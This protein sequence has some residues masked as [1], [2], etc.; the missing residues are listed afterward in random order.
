MAA[1]FKVEVFSAGVGRVARLSPRN[2]CRIVFSSWSRACQW[3]IAHNVLDGDFTTAGAPAFTYVWTTQMRLKSKIQEK[4]LLRGDYNPASHI[5]T[6]FKFNHGSFTFF[7][8]MTHLC[9]LYTISDR[10]V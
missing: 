2:Q 1:D 8:L 6:G 7:D 5:K 3:S 10:H 9:G 4:R